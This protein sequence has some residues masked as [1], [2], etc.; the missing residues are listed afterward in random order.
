MIA[1]EITHKIG[2][3]L[4]A[5]DEIRLSTLRMLSSAL[6]YEKIAKQH[7]L[8]IEEELSVVR[9]AVKQRTDAIESLKAARGKES[10]STPVELEN[11]I[12]KEEAELAVLKEYLPVEMSD[13]ELE[14]I[15]TAVI[16]ETGASDIKDMGRV[17]GGV[18]A[19]SEGRADGAK[20]ASFV[21]SK[22]VG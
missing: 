1:G 5:R 12:K 8:A 7:E 15:V 13:G 2:E 16:E 22:L 14:K 4:K 19:K 10:S 6:N 20:I 3:A 11:K 21:K 17:I 9:K 18:K